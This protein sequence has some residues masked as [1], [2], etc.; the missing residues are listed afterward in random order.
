MAE[1]IRWDW[2]ERHSDDIVRAGGEHL[3]LVGAAIAI[4]TAV[5]VPLGVLVRRS[6]FATAAA[7]TS[8]Q[9]LYTVPSLAMFGFLLPFLGIGRTP[10]IVALVVYSLLGITRNTIVGLQSVPPAVVEAA[11][12][13]GLTRGQTL[14]RVEIPLA[15]PSILTGVRFATVGAVGIATIGAL[16]AGGGLGDLIINDG[17][18][19]DLF[20]TPIV[21][22]VALATALAITLDLL[23][24]LAQR[25]ATPWARRSPT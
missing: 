18:N 25:L 6:R 23:L 5:A 2:I 21:V 9:V 22:G 11:R 24:I 13:M 3:V 16:F 17:L 12:G 20:L 15:T 4:A 8:S 10:V 7:L 1:P 14:L 19:R